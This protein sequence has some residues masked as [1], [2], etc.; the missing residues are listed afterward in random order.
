MTQAQ[1]MRRSSR[2]P[3]A[4][5]SVLESWLAA[6]LG[7]GVAPEVLLYNF[8]GNWLYDA[9]TSEQE[10]L[11]QSTIGAVA[12]LHGIVDAVEHFAFLERP[13]AG[14]THLRRHVAHTRAWYDTVAADGCPSPLV[15]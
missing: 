7:E 8:G 12:A 5:R 6:R 3:D 2:E 4:L 11:Q 13:D 10:R 15:E 9:A 14:D 1:P